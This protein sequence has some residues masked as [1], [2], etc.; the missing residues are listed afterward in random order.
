MAN[1]EQ[2]KISK[3]L[4]DFYN[5]P[6]AK[7][8]AELVFSIIAVIFFAL[9]A[10]RPTLVTMSDLIK[11]IDEKKVLDNQLAQKVAAL[12]SIQN[13][14]LALQD[15]LPLLDE[16]IPSTPEFI[17]AIK[18]IEKLASDHQLMIQSI[19]VPDIPP[20]PTASESADL[21]NKTRLVRPISINV[22]GDY[23]AIRQ[24]IEDMRNLRRTTII[25]SI[26]FSLNDETG[27]KKLRATITVNIVYF[28]VEK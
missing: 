5:K 28:G 4:N 27:S 9:F 13:E 8:S 15:R 16:A 2:R 24:F 12:N 6:V 14:Y 11:E 22:T 1:L 20:E 26:I 23:A 19:S 17:Q 18:L 21:T 25:D 3:T 10:I 7:V